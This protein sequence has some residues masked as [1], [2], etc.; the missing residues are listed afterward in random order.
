MDPKGHYGN[1]LGGA[2]S[3][4]EFEYG[5]HGYSFGIGRL[6]LGRLEP[7]VAIAFAKPN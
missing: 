3:T 7:T 6:L 2:L 5:G 4:I 1:R